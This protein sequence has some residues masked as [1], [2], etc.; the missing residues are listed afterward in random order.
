VAALQYQPGDARLL[1]L[2][3][4][5]EMAAGDRDTAIATFTRSIEVDPSLADPWANRAIIAFRR[6]DLCAARH[7]LTRAAALRED[8]AILYNRGRVL[9]SQRQWQ[10]AA[11]DYARARMLAGADQEAI[12]RGYQ[13]CLKAQRR[14]KLRSR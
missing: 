5:I 2:R 10:K 4:L 7:D 11:D 8:A 9:E 6:G 13:R 3:G 12:D 1:C 14:K